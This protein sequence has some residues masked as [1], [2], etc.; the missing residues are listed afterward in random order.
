M[1]PA[2]YST[3][4]DVLGRYPPLGSVTAVTSLHI[5]Q[6]IGAEQARIDGMLGARYAVPFQPAP[7]LIEMIA[8][9]LTT[10]RLVGT[11]VL[12][13]QQTKSAEEWTE[14]W[15]HSWELLQQLATGEIDLASGSGTPIPQLEGKTGEVWS[16]TMVNTPTFV[17]Q[18]WHKID[19]P[20]SRYW[21]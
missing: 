1:L 4:T 17:G 7:P 6:A 16:N 19:T 2:S 14:T 18:D 11:R 10:L 15:R 9:D 12:L 13:L 8:G 5:L 3:I 20:R 21:P